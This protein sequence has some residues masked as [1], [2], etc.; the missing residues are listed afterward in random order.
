MAEKM[1][2]QLG[3]SRVD[4]RL[5]RDLEAWEGCRHRRSCYYITQFM[6]GNG[7]FGRYT[8]R[9]GKSANDRCQ[10]CGEVDS[11]EHMLR[12]CRRWEEE[13]AELGEIPEVGE[14]VG[15]MV[16]DAAVWDRFYSWI[17]HTMERKEREDRARWG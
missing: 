2:H 8:H 14:L 9:I 12:E 6:T 11:P 13:R 10:E 15:E 5:V 7:S 3:E 17:V 1:G 4:E 16:A